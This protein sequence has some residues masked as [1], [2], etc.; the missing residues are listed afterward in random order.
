MT[1]SIRKLEPVT[2][3]TAWHRLRCQWQGD[4]AIVKQGLPHSQLSP[5]WQILMLGDGSPTRHLQL[6]TGEPTEVDVI[7]MS[8][9]GLAGQQ[10]INGSRNMAPLPRVGAFK[11]WPSDLM[12]FI[13]FIGIEYYL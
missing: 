13:L 5:P 11:H 3:P 1:A 4:E 10:L 6:L 8:A 9:I 12:S 7:D 2:Q